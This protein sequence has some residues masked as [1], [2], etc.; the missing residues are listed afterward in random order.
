MEV[1]E[2]EIILFLAR[3]G[4]DRIH[5]GLWILLEVV[6]HE[7]PLFVVIDVLVCQEVELAIGHGAY[8]VRQVRRAN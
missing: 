5:Q 7:L 1:P 6:E 3:W 8:G 4:R 2:G